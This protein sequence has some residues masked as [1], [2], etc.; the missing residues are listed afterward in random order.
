MASA[1]S[2]RNLPRVLA[3]PNARPFSSASIRRTNT[4]PFSREHQ[5]GR[6]SILAAKSHILRPYIA[7]RLATSP[8]TVQSRT[9]VELKAAGGKTEAD[10]VVEELQELYE[11]P[12][13]SQ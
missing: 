6:L 7:S 8:L 4:C 3:R 2:L 12:L 5:P 9:F 1:N 13:F 10:L 11:S